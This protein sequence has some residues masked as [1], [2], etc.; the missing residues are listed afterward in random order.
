MNKL[1]VAQPLRLQR[2]VDRP[3]PDQPTQHLNRLQKAG[4]ARSVLANEDV[5]W[6][7]VDFHVPQALEIVYLDSRDHEMPPG[8]TSR[9]RPPG[10]TS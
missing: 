9:V 5:E 3:V 1:V 7:Q 10:L 4:L 6:T 2:I 8:E